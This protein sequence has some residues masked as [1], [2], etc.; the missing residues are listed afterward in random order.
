MSD[1]VKVSNLSK[2][3]TT[4]FIKGIFKNIAPILKVTFAD[5]QT[6]II[7]FNSFEGANRAVAQMNYQNLDGSKILVELYTGPPVADRAKTKPR[8]EVKAKAAAGGG[9]NSNSL[10]V[11]M[12]VILAVLIAFL[13]NSKDSS[14]SNNAATYSS[15]SGDGYQHG[16]SRE[17]EYTELYTAHLD[18]TG[19]LDMAQY[20]SHSRD[21]V[22]MIHTLSLPLSHTQTRILSLCIYIYICH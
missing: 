19:T 1:A 17:E 8:A 9:G 6:A 2:G 12:G 21:T 7:R 13:L 11:G 16:N 5:E 18:D 14:K 15:S 10:W 3:S 4:S 20:L 22:Y